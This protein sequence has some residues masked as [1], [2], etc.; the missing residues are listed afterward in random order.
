[1]DRA[2]GIGKDND[3]PWHL[4]ADM[5]F[6]RETTTGHI[7]VMGRKNYESIPEKFR[8]L[9][10]RENAVLSRSEDFKAEGCRVFHSLEACLDHYR[11]E[12]ARTVYIIGGAQI[13]RQVLE[14]GHV[15][16]MYITHIDHTYDADTFF[17]EFNEAGWHI[18]TVLTHP[19]DEKN[20]VPFTVKRYT[21]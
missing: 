10:N 2:R 17:P 4:P 14:G 9:P 8:P 11:N 6:F 1:M 20:A 16:E 7:V 21:R 13:F 5:K 12:T 19:A 18:E 15:T 3:L